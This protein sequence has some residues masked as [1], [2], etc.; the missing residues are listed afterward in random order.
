VIPGGKQAID[1][2]CKSGHALEFLKDQY[3]HCK[4]ILLLGIARTLLDEAGIPTKLASG[5][6]DAGLLN[7]EESEV[8]ASLQAFIDALTKHR[9][10]ERETDPPRV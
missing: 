5:E 8:S 1:T 4:P 10:F 6:P 7:F 3:R 9:T 2:L